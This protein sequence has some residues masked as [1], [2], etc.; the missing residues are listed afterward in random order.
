MKASLT[1]APR[2]RGWR[3]RPTPPARR[4]RPRAM[5]VL[6]PLLVAA[7]R[8]P[9]RRL[10]QAIRWVLLRCEGGSPLSVHL[11]RVFAL[12]HGV[13]VGMYTHGGW[14]FPFHLGE[15]TTV[16]RFCSIADSARVI[17]HN[18][19]LDWRSTSGLFFHP[20]FGLTT[21]PVPHNRIDI[22]N[23]VWIGHNA[24]ILPAVRS[25][26]DGAVIGAGAVVHRDVPAYA[27]VS[28]QPA[29]V[30]GYRFSAPRIEQ[31]RSSRWWDRAI[32]QLLPELHEFQRPIETAARVRAAANAPT[33]EPI[34]ELA[35]E[36]AP[37]R[38]AEPAA[39]SQ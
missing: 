25:I 3:R 38:A 28:G 20:A 8:L 4:L 17:T 19:P 23:D 2:G 30:V 32:E 9:S 29:R 13:D 36:P 21:A 27:I 18:H 34:A 33:A 35:A 1:C 24:T 39:E 15:G 26:G 16:G 14:V 37:E 6:G 31:L 10:R 7:Y 5:P 12:Y 11:R 22:G